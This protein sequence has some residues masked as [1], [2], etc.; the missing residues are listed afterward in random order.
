M[1]F[2]P[3]TVELGDNNCPECGAE[4][5]SGAQP[6]RECGAKLGGGAAVPTV[7]AVAAPKPLKTAAP[8]NAPKAP[9]PT[10]TGR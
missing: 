8:P 3:P 2:R 5:Y 9:G 1:C 6:G 10:Q 7:A 4:L